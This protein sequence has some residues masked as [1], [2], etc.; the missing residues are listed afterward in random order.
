MTG[1]QQ[2]SLAHAE[3]GPA[4]QRLNQLLRPEV[5]SRIVQ[6]NPTALAEY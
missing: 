3:P 2:L 1:R 5:F 4:A 6:M